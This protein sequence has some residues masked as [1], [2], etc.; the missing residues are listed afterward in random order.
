MID[1]KC[2]VILSR[3]SCVNNDKQ[4]HMKKKRESTEDP[5]LLN[6]SI[7]KNIRFLTRDV[8]HENIRV[9]KNQRSKVL[10]YVK[11]LCINK[12]MRFP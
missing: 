11:T 1:K 9:R 8:T 12:P 4:C 3:I 10:G 2:S 6:S 7:N 5:N